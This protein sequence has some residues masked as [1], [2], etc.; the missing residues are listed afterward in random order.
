MKLSSR[1]RS[2]LVTGLLVLAGSWPCV[3]RAQSS[4]PAA[5]ETVIRITNGNIANVTKDGQPVPATLQRIVDI[6]RAEYRSASITIVGVDDVLIQNVT[7]RMAPR[8]ASLRSA[9]IALVEASGRKFRVDASSDQDFALLADRSPVGHRI[10]EVFNLGPLLSSNRASHLDRQ[11]RDLEMN[12]AATRKVMGAEHSRI[13]DI[14]TEIEL[15]KA[16][17]AQT[18]SAPN[19]AKVIEQIQ[20]TVDVTLRLLRSAEKQPEFQF[21][22]GTNLLIVVGGN[23]AIEVTRKVV[24]ALQKGAN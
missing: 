12:L 1:F 13:K 9:L 4:P 5:P 18:S 8:A 2:L 21:H 14:T 6:L 20:E 7:L 16:H 11:L 10:A 3:T 15:I 24:A 17:L 23:D 22:P 19:S